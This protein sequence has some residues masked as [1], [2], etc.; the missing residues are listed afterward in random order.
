MNR[1]SVWGRALA[2]LLI[3]L[4]WFRLHSSVF[5]RKAGVDATGYGRCWRSPYATI[6]YAVEHCE[7]GDTVFVDAGHVET[8][9][10]PEW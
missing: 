7:P 10:S 9:Q 4:P 8:S 5:V 6:S 1:R 2:L 3:P